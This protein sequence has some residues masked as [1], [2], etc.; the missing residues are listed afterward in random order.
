MERPD[1][2]P[3]RRPERLLHLTRTKHGAFDDRFDRRWG[4]G[5]LEGSAAVRDK[6][7]KVKHT[8]LSSTSP[9]EKVLPIIRRND[10]HFGVPGVISGKNVVFFPSS[11][12]SP[13]PPDPWPCRMSVVW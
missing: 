12:F 3:L 7:L 9:G 5:V 8:L 11:V 4:G 2:R 13:L 6:T 10:T 1:F